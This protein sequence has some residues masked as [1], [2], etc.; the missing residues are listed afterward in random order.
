MSVMMAEVFPSRMRE[1]I[2]VIKKVDKDTVTLMS[3]ERN[4][5]QDGLSVLGV[6]H[7]EWREGESVMFHLSYATTKVKL[8]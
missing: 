5:Q 7:L 1:G 4:L 8:R 2:S 3:H 6:E